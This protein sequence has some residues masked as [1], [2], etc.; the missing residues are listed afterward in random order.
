VAV[1]AGG[2]GGVAGR[3]NAGGWRRGEGATAVSRW[4]HCLAICFFFVL[5]NT[6]C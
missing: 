2:A 5:G 1:A 4:S 3:R 6:L